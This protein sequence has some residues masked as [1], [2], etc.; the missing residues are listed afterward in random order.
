MKG[1][2][3]PHGGKLCD[4]LETSQNIKGIKEKAGKLPSLSLSP[5]QICDLELLLNGA[6]SPLTGFMGKE[7][8]ES[9]LESMR[10]PNG[11]IW[12]LPVTLDVSEA[13]LKSLGEHS[14]VVLRD[15]EGFPLAVLEIR[16][17]WKADKT[18]EAQRA[19]GTTSIDH[20]QVAF[21]QKRC[22]EYYLGGRIRGIS[23]PRYYDFQEL[24]RAPAELRAMFEKGGHSTVVAFQTRNPM[25]RAHVELTKRAAE[26]VGGHLLIHPVVGQTKPGDV[27]HFTRVRCYRQALKYYPQNS[28]TLSLLPLAMRMGGPKEALLHAIIRKNYGCTHLIVGR[29]HAGPGKDTTGKPFY[30]PYDAQE[31]LSAHSDELGVRMVPFKNMLYVKGQ[32]RYFP[33]DELP[34]GAETA[35]VSGTQLRELLSGGKEIPGWYSYP[36]VVTELRKAY[37]AN[38]KKGMVIFMTGLP[39]SGKSTLA[40]ALVMRLMEVDSRRITLLDGDVVRKNL[41]A[42][43]G[44]SRQDRATQ[45]RRVGFIAAEI[46]KHGGTVICALIAPYAEDRQANREAV[47]QVAEYIEVFVNTPVNVCE[48]RDPKGLYAKARSGLIKGF[49]G[50]DDPYEAPAAPEINVAMG[51]LSVEGG[52]KQVTDYLASRGFISQEG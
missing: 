19:F 3:S 50:I 35:D 47:S 34:A 44:F 17:S 25:H 52:V 43:L 21:L 31:L 30:G 9:V 15:P 49:T 28:V 2:I 45:V 1:L 20:P 37:P 48:V 24:R 32:D 7:E 16:E 14:E 10:L 41:T 29:D 51:D 26:Q 39:S 13:L 33:E 4:L 12:P 22:G 6:F 42:E 46:A 5:R 11:V 18:T 40:N 27:D 38:S 23:L 36:E 8:Y